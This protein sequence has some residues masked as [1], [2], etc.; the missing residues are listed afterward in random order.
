MS[1]ALPPFDRFAS[2]AHQIMWLAERQAQRR[3]HQL[4][5]TEHLLFGL[6]GE[7][8]GLAIT[9]L[10]KLGIK[11]AQIAMDLEHRLCCETKA[12]IAARP[13]LSSA[14]ERVIQLA[15]EGADDLGYEYVGSEHLLLG[16][17][18]EGNGLASTTLR[19]L[20]LTT[21]AV[22]EE[23][24]RFASSGGADVAAHSPNLN[25]GSLREAERDF[26]LGLYRSA[27]DFYKP[28]I[29]KKAGVALGDIAVRDYTCMLDD[30]LRQEQSRLS[31]IRFVRQFLFRKRPRF[32]L[33]AVTAAFDESA[34]NCC[35]A[36]RHSAIYVSF[37]SGTAH[38]EVIA[39]AVVHELAH[40]LWEKLAARPLTWRP[41][42]K[43]MERYSLLVEG[44]ATYAEQVWFLELYPISIRRTVQQSQLDPNGLHY[45]GF[46]WVEQLVQE[47]GAQILMK[48]PKR[49]RRIKLSS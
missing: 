17:L 46:R 14:A 45:R 35:A 32:D 40:A 24:M 36:Y 20:G 27:V 28:R 1:T 41:K 44:F 37:R 2:S 6:I 31:S 8:G 42:G 15:A 39:R 22:R 12:P 43:L 4:I 47:H 11:P 30:A 21:E 9:V 19:G 33:E 26:F 48:I 3:G 10:K 7:E 49:W 16:L 38:E 13:W 34:K 18:R 29:E 25:H 5:G 23:I